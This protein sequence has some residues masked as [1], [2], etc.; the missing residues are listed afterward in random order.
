LDKIAE[1]VRGTGREIV[2]W[3]GEYKYFPD[4]GG[5]RFRWPHAIM[6]SNQIATSRNQPCLP[7][8]SDRS[9]QPIFYTTAPISMFT[10]SLLIRGGLHTLLTPIATL[11]GYLGLRRIAKM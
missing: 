10:L 2:V 7:K 8:P 5:W 11:A 3:V 1:I 4:L 6:D 9:T